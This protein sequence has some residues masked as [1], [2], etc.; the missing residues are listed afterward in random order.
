MKIQKVKFGELCVSLRGSADENVA[1]VMSDDR[2]M[3]VSEIHPITFNRSL[4]RTSSDDGQTAE[5]KVSKLL[6]EDP[7]LSGGGGQEVCRS[8]ERAR[9]IQ[10]PSDASHW[11]LCQV[12]KEI[13]LN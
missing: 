4:R 3:S 2:E 13:T 7:S 9:R 8:T 12:S 10:T 6:A 5:I 1:S 11:H